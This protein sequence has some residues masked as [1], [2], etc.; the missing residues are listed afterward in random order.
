M[1]HRKPNNRFPTPVWIQPLNVLNWIL[2]NV[3]G[4]RISTASIAIC[5]ASAKR[6]SSLPH[7][8]AG[9]STAQS[10]ATTHW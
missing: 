4:M 8:I 9:A 6:I 10:L 2:P 5:Y 1:A 7:K 3:A